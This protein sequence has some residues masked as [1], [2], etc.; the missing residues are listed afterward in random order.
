MEFKRFTKICPARLEEMELVHNQS[1]WF[2]LEQTM[3]PSE[4]LSV[5][6]TY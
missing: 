5:N 4:S 2:H 6:Q 1:M 3:F